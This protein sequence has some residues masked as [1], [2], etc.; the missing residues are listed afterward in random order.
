[1]RILTFENNEKNLNDL[2]RLTDRIAIEKTIDATFDS[3]E[4]LQIYKQN[5]YDIVLINCN[6]EVGI[7]LKNEIRQLNPSQRVVVVNNKLNCNESTNCDYCKNNT[8][9]L[10]IFEPYSIE[11]IIRLFKDQKCEHN[12]CHPDTQ[13]KLLIISKGY[14]DLNYNPTNNTFSTSSG[15]KDILSHLS[16]IDLCQ[17]LKKNNINF[18]IE[19]NVLKVLV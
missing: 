11:D 18:T 8:N 16:V 5:S 15:K 4:L 3:N 10:R 6:N 19:N 9:T 7:K 1:M 17:E 12:Y 14:N 13:T 2:Y